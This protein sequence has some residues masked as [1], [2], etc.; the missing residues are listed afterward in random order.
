MFS[1]V[2]IVLVFLAFAAMMIM[3]KISAIIAM[4]VMAVVIALL[5]G[6]CSGMPLFGANSV[7][8]FVFSEVMT[9]GSF[10]LG[11]AM[12]YAVFGAVLSQVVQIT[13]IA[14]HFV[15][16]AAELAG[17]RRLVLA[18][19]L[20][21]ASTVV[22]GS[23]SGLGGFI[24]VAS[25]VLPVMTAA[26]ISPSL[27]SCLILF[28]LSIGGVFNPAN[29]GF[30]KDALGI[31]LEVIKGLAVSYAALLSVAAVAFLLIELKRE[32]KR[33]F[34]AVSVPQKEK[35]LSPFALL[36]PVLPILL[37]INPLFPLPVIPAFVIA[38]LYGVLVSDFRKTLQNSTA[39]FV[40][41]LKDVS[42][43]LGLFIGI[44]MLLNSVI[45]EPV[46]S[47]MK[48]FLQ[49]IVPSSPFW[50][51]VFFFLLAPLAL[52]RGPFN[53]FGL[54][55]GLAAIL[56]SAGILPPAAV[57]AA[58]LSVGQIQGVCDPT[59]THNAWLAQYMKV[60][61][62]DLMKRTIF[63]VWGFVL[64]ALVYAVIFMHVL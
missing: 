12:M 10:R 51:V 23:V 61:V 62:D 52:Y 28:S 39:A 15:R 30:Y 60:P 19:G 55:S 31:S 16:T 35:R 8:D 45:S 17:D 44:G 53:L 37:I 40:E 9:K 7:S 3:K 24:M 49:S 56:V 13:G 5:A 38:S 20:T 42:P 2:L 50:F 64:L 47:V 6:L 46:T 27:A 33:V 58:F 54:G 18:L 41:G 59:N 26:G 36:T 63:Y 1:A 34:W 57:M 32:R 25:L 4:P 14:K 43:V 21:A 48:P 22:F 29:W 11:E